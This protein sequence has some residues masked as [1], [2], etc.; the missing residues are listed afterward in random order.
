MKAKTN[1]LLLLLIV[2]VIV[3]QYPYGDSFNSQSVT[4]IALGFVML[5]GYLFGELI[6][7]IAL[8]RITGYLLAGMILGPYLGG[9]LTA[10]TITNLNLIDNIALAL[11]ALTAGGE[12]NLRSIKKRWKG[13]AAISCCQIIGVTLL[14][15]TAFYV[16]SGTLAFM[17]EVSTPSL[18]MASLLFGIIA[19]SQSPAVTIA[20][21]TETKSKGITTES[22]L[23]VSVICDILVIVLYS[24]ALPVL[25]NIELGKGGLGLDTF[26]TIGWEI[27][28][29][30]GFGFIAG[31]VL[32][33]YLKYIKTNPVLF[34]LA[35]CYL[36]SEGSHSIHLDPVIVCVTAGIWVTN[37][38][39]R[40][41]SLIE[42]IESGSIIIYVIFFC[43][44]GASLNLMAVSEMWFVGLVL[45]VARIFFMFLM[46]NLAVKVTN[47]AVPDFKTFWMAF[48]PQAGVSLGLVALLSR[49]PVPWADGF[50]TLLIAIIAM[51]QIIGPVTTKV[52]FQRAG[53]T[54]RPAEPEISP[55]LTST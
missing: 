34:L 8:P 42:T 30:I 40:G 48:L 49:H 41:E 55:G 25:I 4:V 37:A 20:I 33:V 26:F 32:D 6:A 44:A 12:L 18:L 54:H 5:A 45:V 31:W 2:V 50:M 15:G 53:E 19:V 7:R 39:K 51:N 14:A 28:L 22:A 23:G 29:S 35:F 52:A 16:L 3:R 13:I 9:M 46:T 47:Y 21:I 17:D 36:V 10:D 43:V 11:I 27:F 24:I 38:S 1:A